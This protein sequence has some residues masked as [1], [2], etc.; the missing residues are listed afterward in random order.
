MRNPKSF[1]LIII[2]VSV[3]LLL[4]DIPKPLKLNFQTKI[5][6]INKKIAISEFLINPQDLNINLG[7]ARIQ[8]NIGYRLGLDLQGGVRLV[9]KVDMENIPKNERPNAFESARNIIERRI[10]FFGVVEPTIQTLKISEDYRVIVELPGITNV[11]EATSLIG[12]TA[13][14]SF[15]E[16]GA[17]GS[18]TTK[19]ATP[20][21]GLP[22]GVDY[23]LGAGAK[24]TD[25][26]GKDLQ[27]TKVVFDPNTGKPQV[28]L[29]FTNDGSK[30]FADITKRNVG[31]PV[32]IVLDN[33]VIEAPRVNEPI[34]TGSAVITGS[35]AV[36]QAKSLSIALN[37]GALPA[38]LQIISQSNVG[39]SLGMESLKKSLFAGLVGFVSIVIF[40]TVLYKK[41]GILASIALIMYVILTLF[42]FKFIPVTLT[43]AGI[44]GL[45][46]SVGMAVD[47]NILIFER[48]K[49]E[50]RSGKPRDIAVENGFKRAWTSI[51]DSNISS[52]ITSFILYYFGSGIVRG[53]AFT[54]AIG[55]LISM[56]S[57]IT[58]TRNLLRIFDRK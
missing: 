52:L 43:L 19:I 5:P 6:F 21:S 8:K 54:L 50:L 14:L 16:E 12:K 38:P 31:K 30:K 4:L 42:I 29:S 57:A 40:M 7:I 53:F 37:A 35:F 39:P 46:L 56:F 3:F 25:L 17:T 9:Y 45:I 27:N 11:D 33:Q 28:Q 20:S 49:E 24:K 13:Q 22:F 36:A 44:A 55:I 48:M 18:A 1:I 58:I 15:W 41:E 10:N 51:R 26:T 2:F 47:A 32:A 34:L 23:V